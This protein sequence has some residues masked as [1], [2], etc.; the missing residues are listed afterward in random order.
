MTNA[1]VVALVELSL[2]L[3]LQGG[4]VGALGV[5]ACVRI[6]EVVVVAIAVDLSC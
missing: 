1:A 4:G 3:E 6:D 5:E 2:E